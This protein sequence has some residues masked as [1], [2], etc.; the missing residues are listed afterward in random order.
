MSLR[1]AI[2]DIAV[3]WISTIIIHV[4]IGN[5]LLESLPS[6]EGFTSSYPNGR[7]IEYSEIEFSYFFAR[8]TIELRLKIEDSIM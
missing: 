1:G 5:R 6:E 2:S 4:E 3:R 8:K 7:P